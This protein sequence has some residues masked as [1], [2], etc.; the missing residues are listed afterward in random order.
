M[1]LKTWTGWA[2]QE[3]G[4]GR[5]KEKSRAN[6]GHGMNWPRRATVEEVSAKWN[7]KDQNWLAAY[8]RQ[9]QENLKERAIMVLYGSRAR[10][11][12][13]EESDIDI[14]LI[15]EGITDHERRAWRRRA[16]ELTEKLEASPS[17]LAMDKKTWES[18]KGRQ[19][20]SE[21][22]RDGVLLT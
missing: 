15:T 1:E 21:I 12:W 14:L 19:L 18:M 22:R 9:V 13:T 17:V 4:G 8:A 10:E 11:T 2:D 3:E 16:H 6:S 7:A 20:W 5:P